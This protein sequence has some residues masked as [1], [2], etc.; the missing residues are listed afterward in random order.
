MKPTKAER[1]GEQRENSR[2]R[3]MTI[4]EYNN[5]SNILVEFEDGYITRTKYAIFKQ[6]YIKH[7]EDFPRG[8]QKKRK[9]REIIHNCTINLSPLSFL[10]MIEALEVY[11][12]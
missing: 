10:D 4:I 2:G 3:L 11:E 9:E 5:A 12:F 6:G 8:R 7:I 1:I